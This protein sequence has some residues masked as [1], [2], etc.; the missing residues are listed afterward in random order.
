M[1]N[2]SLSIRATL[3]RWKVKLLRRLGMLGGG[4]Q[5]GTHS[6]TNFWRDA[7]RDPAKY[8]LA[9]VF[10]FRTEPEAMLQPELCELLAQLDTKHVR[11]LDVGAGPLSSLGKRWPDHEVEIVPVDPLCADYDRFLSE[12]NVIPP[13]RTTKADAES[14]T[15]RFADASFDMAYASNSLDHCRDPILAISEMLKVVRP[16]GY[17]YLWHFADEGEAEN[18]HGL[19][20]WN[21]GARSGD[22]IVSD[23]RKNTSLRTKFGDGAQLTVQEITA[24]GKPVAIGILRKNR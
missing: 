20:Q 10:K 14:L 24:Y 11:I 23:G 19:H 12:A 13:V 17:V 3:R 9:D 21:I 6:E 8:W 4:W 1:Q 18:Y 2:E 16:G 15:A 7:L 5:E 22:I